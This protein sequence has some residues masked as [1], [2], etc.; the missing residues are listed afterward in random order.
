[1]EAAFGNYSVDED[2]ATNIILEDNLNTE[3][4]VAVSRC[5]LQGVAW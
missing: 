4:N 3:T 1:M 2:K 5:P